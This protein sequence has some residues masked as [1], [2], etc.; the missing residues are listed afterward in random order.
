VVLSSF[1]ENGLVPDWP[2]FI[3]DAIR[4]EWNLSGLRS[5]IEVSV[6]DV[7][8]PHYRDEVLKKYDEYVKTSV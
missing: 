2:S 4:C 3:E 8:G 7:Y 6:G 5:K 1:K